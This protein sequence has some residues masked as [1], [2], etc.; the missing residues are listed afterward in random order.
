MKL[1]H[2][3]INECA[4]HIAEKSVP[5]GNGCFEY[6][7][8]IDRHTGYPNGSKRIRGKRD[9]AHVIAAIV[10]TGRLPNKGETASHTCHN[11]HCVSPKHVVFESQSE[12]NLRSR[13]LYRDA[14]RKRYE[15]PVKKA[16][17]TEANLKASRSRPSN[18]LTMKDAR[19]IRR[20]Y[21]T[22]DYT[23]T[24]LAEIYKCSQATIY[25]VVNNKQWR[26]D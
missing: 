18:K 7:G 5:V 16:R 17:H 11:K 22:G 9:R 2:S 26:E 15:D 19:E 20:L 21:A 6:A 23:Q 8:K 3:E 24:E 25:M 10:G 1:T 12:N 13:E 4:Y 14:A